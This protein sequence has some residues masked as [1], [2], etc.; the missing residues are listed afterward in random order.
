MSLSVTMDMSRSANAS[1]LLG[2]SLLIDGKGKSPT[3]GLTVISL[4]G[5]GTSVLTDTLASL[6]R[7]AAEALPTELSAGNAEAAGFAV[8]DAFSVGH[9]LVAYVCKGDAGEDA[10]FDYV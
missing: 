8:V 10:R 1:T 9:L 2:S 4:T 3:T 6:E 5:H 7:I